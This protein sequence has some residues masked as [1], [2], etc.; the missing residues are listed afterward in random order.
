MNENLA[1]IGAISALWKVAF[2][3]VAL[4]SAH[5]GAFDLAAWAIVLTAIPS[6]IET[7]RRAT[8][9]TEGKSDRAVRVVAEA[10]SFGGATAFVVHETYTWTEPW[11]VV[12]ASLFAIAAT[13]GVARSNI[14]PG[15]RGNPTTPGLPAAVAAVL[16]TTAY[17]F[18]GAPLV[19]SVLGGLL[20]SQE[21]GGVM[22]CLLILMVSPVPYPVVIPSKRGRSPMKIVGVALAAAA[23]LT[24]PVYFVFPVA[25]GYTFWG[26]G[27][28][29]TPMLTE[30]V[31]HGGVEADRRPPGES[32]EDGPDYNSRYR[33]R[34]TWE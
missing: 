22:I 21:V 2:A 20:D 16:L 13:V 18:F 6:W 8:G 15:P 26:V 17:P 11:G 10:I 28:S 7:C 34:S 9:R 4:G 25:V 32:G 12:V 3:L 31:R 29:V 30:G 1:P 23:A 33:P 27:E 24:F 5:R 19:A 14:E